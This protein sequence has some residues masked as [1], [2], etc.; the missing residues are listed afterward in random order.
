MKRF[1]VILALCFA[2][3]I[4]L[5]AGVFLFHMFR[6]S[7]AA[8]EVVRSGGYTVPSLNTAKGK[9][10]ASR[11]PAGQNS[12]TTST[13]TSTGVSESTS[14]SSEDDLDTIIIDD[15]EQLDNLE[16]DIEQL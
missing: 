7:R 8:E 2:V 15:D 4:V 10:P 14:V 9:T 12:S 11:F 3:I 1:H 16:Q 5:I 6:V 13:E